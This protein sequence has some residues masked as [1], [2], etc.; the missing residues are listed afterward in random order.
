MDA[1][2]E[3]ELREQ[4]I[5]CEKWGLQEG[6]LVWIRFFVECDA[7]W[8]RDRFLR[9]IGCDAYDAQ[10]Q[11]DSRHAPDGFAPRQDALISGQTSL[12]PFSEGAVREQLDRVCRIAEEWES[13]VISW[14]LGEPAPNA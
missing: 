11:H 9:A 8:K 3:E 1:E 10:A 7:R 14:H 4:L 6:S 5:L 13:R 12:F 2:I